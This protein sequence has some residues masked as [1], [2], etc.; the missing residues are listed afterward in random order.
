MNGEGGV[1]GEEGRGDLRPVPAR[2]S[3]R[4]AMTPLLK[5][6]LCLAQPAC[7]LAACFVD[8]NWIGVLCAGFLSTV[9]RGNMQA[10]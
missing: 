10:I 3:N 7:E 4:F 8:M 5:H 2:D 6:M 9:Q 1:G